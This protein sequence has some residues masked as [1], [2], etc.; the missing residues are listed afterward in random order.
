MSFFLKIYLFMAVLG[1]GCCMRASS[2]CDAQ[3]FL[4]ASLVA[5]L[6]LDSCDARA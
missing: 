1:L 6:R 2:G 4:V 3:P 5:E